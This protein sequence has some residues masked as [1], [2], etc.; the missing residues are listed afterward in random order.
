LHT[1]CLCKLQTVYFSLCGRFAQSRVYT[2][3]MLWIVWFKKDLRLTDH[4]PLVWATEQARASG[5]AVLPLWV[6]EPQ[7]WR[8]ADASARHWRFAQDCLADLQAALFA[9][10]AALLRVR[11]DMPKVLDKLRAAVGEFHLVSFE[12][13]GNGWSYARDLAVARWCKLHA[14]AWREFPSNGVVRRL[15]SRDRW[16]A[17]WAQRMKAAPLPAPTHVNWA[18]LPFDSQAL[19]AKVLPAWDVSPPAMQIQ[20]GG[21]TQALVDL[22]SFLQVR[23]Q[24]YRVDMSSPL[25]GALSCSRISA[26]LAWGSLSIKEVLHAVQARRA[27]LLELAFD[28][29]PA[30]FLASLKSFES[31]LHW[32]CHFIQK[33][34]SEPAIEFRNVNRGFDGIRNEGELFPEEAAKLI[35]WAEGKTGLPFVDACMR[36]LIAT[37]WINFRMRAMLVSFASYHLW[38]HWRAT[39]CHLARLFTDYEPGIHWSQFQMQSGVTGI[40]T[41]RIYNPIKQSMDQDPDGVFIRT[42]LPELV[43]VAQQYIH[44]PWKSPTPPAGYPAPIVDVQLAARAAKERIYGKKNEKTVKDIAQTVYQKHGSRSPARE[45]ARKRRAPVAATPRASAGDVAMQLSLDM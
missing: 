34:E 39:G 20:R 24:H 42:W 12:E 14:V 31:R 21:R 8:Q 44:E 7:M 29:R 33:L 28:Q 19:A 30:G 38:L 43:G 9:D 13:S 16:A 3:C 15:A 1:L 4:A 40:N 41:I 18:R 23:G 27:A 22:Q 11:G 32:H 17:Q 26:H 2:A 37:G 35:A 6:D 5:G 45:G 10:G 36:S 25:A